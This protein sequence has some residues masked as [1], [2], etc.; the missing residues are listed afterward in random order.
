M[1]KTM[2]SS[3]MYG[4]GLVWCS[5]QQNSFD[6][7]DST[8]YY[9]DTICAHGCGIIIQQQQLAPGLY[10]TALQTSGELPSP[11]LFSNR[12]AAR[13]KLA[14]WEEALHDIMEATKRDPANPKVCRC[15]S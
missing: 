6:R 9:D 5:L 7:R 1:E 4:I 8:I 12:A 10:S 14:K 15:L 3:K 11:R 2:W 13:L